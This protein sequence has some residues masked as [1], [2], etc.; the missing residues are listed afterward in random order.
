MIDQENEMKKINS[1]LRE[2]ILDIAENFSVIS[3]VKSKISRSL[4]GTNSQTLFLNWLNE[5]K[6]CDFGYRPISKI[7]NSLGYKVKIIFIKNG[8]SEIEDFIDETNKKFMEDAKNILSNYLKKF[9]EDREN[10]KKKTLDP[11]IAEEIA[12]IYDDL[13][14]ENDSYAKLVKS[15]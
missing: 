5:R 11:E 15:S 7:A 1:S 12:N 4:V 10:G 2:T 6:K 3:G 13:F 14:M 9:I 8:D